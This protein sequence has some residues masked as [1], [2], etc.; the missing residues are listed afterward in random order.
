MSSPYIVQWLDWNSYPFCTILIVVVK[1]SNT[2]I[3]DVIQKQSFKVLSKHLLHTAQLRH[4]NESG[5]ARLTL[6]SLESNVKKANNLVQ[7]F[8]NHGRFY[9][10]MRLQNE[11]KTIEFE[12]S[13]S[14]LAIIHKLNHGIREKK[15]D[16]AFANDM[17]EELV[18]AVG[19]PVKDNAITNV[20]E[21]YEHPSGAIH[22]MASNNDSRVRDFDMER[23][24]LSKHFYFPWPINSSMPE[25][26]SV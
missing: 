6:E 1:I 16:Q 4:L 18:K 3:N 14:Q 20:V 13:Q 11:M 26:N 24:H 5:A 10:L 17:L 25:Y 15:L 9:L 2:T 12:A 23:F 22:F 8:I 21:I 19:V 7:M